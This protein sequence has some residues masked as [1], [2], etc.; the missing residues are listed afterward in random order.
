MIRLKSLGQC[1]IEAGSS[2]LGPETEILFGVLLYL[3]MERGRRVSRAKLAE[4]FWPEAAERRA[5]H[6]LRQTLYRLRTMDSCI[7]TD[8]SSAM[9]E[10][11][12]AD[13]DYA[14]YLEDA[15]ELP[16]GRAD[17]T[18]VATFLPGYSPTFSAPF[19][20]W[21]DQQR[22][23]VH[24]ILRRTLV[25]AIQARKAR[26]DWRTVEVL[27]ASCFA[28]DP[29]NEEATLALA[30]ASAV[31]GS[32]VR[33]IG[34]LDRYMKEIG[35]DAREIRIPA[36]ILRRRI[37]ETTSQSGGAFVP[38]IELPF[39]G[40]QAEMAALNNALESARGGN[41][42]AH[43]FW[44]EAGIGKTRLITE[45][46]KAAA[47]KGTQVVRVGCQSHDVRRPLS[48]FVDLVPK[49]LALRGAIGC[50]PES[51][52]FLRRLVEHDPRNK[53]LSP[54]A[55]ESELLQAGIRRAIFDLLD[56]VTGEKC[57][58][59]VFEDVQWLDAASWD[60]LLDIAPWV[61]T[62]GCLLL[63]TA[64]EGETGAPK[65]T[66]GVMGLIVRQL[67]QLPD[68]ACDELVGA[69]MSRRGGEASAE[70]REWCLRRGGGNPF[71]LSELAMR[72]QATGTGFTVPES[73]NALITARL[74]SLRPASLRALQACAVLGKYATLDRIEGLLEQRRLEV[75]D[76][77]DEL[78]AHA[79]IECEG[80]G[81]AVQIKHD[82]LSQA[83][84]SRL[85]GPSRQMLHRYAARLLESL[86]E[87]APSA[88]VMWDC[89]EHWQNAGEVGRAIELL[90]SCARHSM[91]MGF[92]GEAAE[93]LRRALVMRPSPEHAASVLEEYLR[94]LF[95]AAE[96]QQLVSAVENASTIHGV[97]DKLYKG[98][99]DVELMFIESKW[100]AGQ[101]PWVQCQ[102]LRNCVDGPAAASHRVKAATIALIIADNLCDPA[103]AHTICE[104]TNNLIG[105]SNLD[106]PTRQKFLLV[107]QTSF[108]DLSLAAEAARNLVRAEREYGNPAALVRALVWASHGLRSAGHLTES[109]DFL[110]EAFGLATTHGL[111]TQ[112]AVVAGNAANYCLESDELQT[113]RSWYCHTGASRDRLSGT[114]TGSF[115]AVVGAE[116]AM[117]EGRHEDAYS[118]LA[119]S[120]SALP[121]KLQHM[122]A[123]SN[124]LSLKILLD[125]STDKT[126][127]D[128]QLNELLAHHLRGRSRLLQDLVTVAVFRACK[129]RGETSRGYALVLDYFLK[130][131]RG[132]A[133]ARSA[134]LELLHEAQ[135]TTTLTTS[136]QG[137]SGLSLEATQ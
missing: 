19:A 136:N 63:L 88:S 56:A 39:V 108:G 84:M 78:E 81:P 1:V 68:G 104:A 105:D 18:V 24:A 79:L 20:D 77:F 10:D 36:A 28:L 8:H 59:V 86:Q 66:G 71:Y 94:I 34:I 97:D 99:S 22:D 131:R 27:A 73:L 25:R 98:H 76:S 125:V 61:A 46:S 126:I 62:R 127:G 23:A 102:Y 54:E 44:G 69:I 9:I 114:L 30:E 111:T 130:Y 134:L 64:R 40:R 117:L 11:S 120:E 21:V 93:S 137:C 121:S 67:R 55:G 83:A 91:E 35:P 110:H 119:S 124:I 112:A 96:F 123:Q 90:R 87:S 82:L 70:F 43:L 31:H 53:T 101:N 115:L 92:P 45:F 95:A 47:L 13:V 85:S 4:I 128:A 106:E 2:R 103:T 6:C 26:G 80:L 7:E 48:L 42:G 12:N 16:F 113:A 17:Q 38:M 60:L 58:V 32:K 72:S 49:L 41:G 37:S 57:I 14:V 109:M 133:P 116:L 51:M 15:L 3:V 132:M 74:C 100:R 118:L 75:L 122:T 65:Q 135:A 89:A 129:V 107:W 5:N 29:L 50:S 52:G 33:A